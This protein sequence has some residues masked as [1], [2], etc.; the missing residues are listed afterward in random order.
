M[1]PIQL[2]IHNTHDFS[3]YYLKMCRSTSI[4]CCIPIQH[5]AE[6][7]QLFI[8]TPGMSVGMTFTLFISGRRT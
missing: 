2:F 5:L 8:K 3:L 1:S 4:C 7:P 6:R